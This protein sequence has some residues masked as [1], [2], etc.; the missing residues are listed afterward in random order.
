MD[1]VWRLADPTTGHLVWKRQAYYAAL[2]QG[3]G[4]IIFDDAGGRLVTRTWW[5]HGAVKVWDVTSGDSLAEL[6]FTWPVPALAVSPD[7]RYVASARLGVFMFDMRKLAWAKEL[8]RNDWEI[9]SVA[10]SPDGRLLACG[11]GTGV[12]ARDVD[13]PVMI[14]DFWLRVWRVPQ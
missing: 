1:R 11:G 13:G 12:N 3:V 2:S 14:D 6:P 8:T 4:T 7:G 9:R 10:F 5:A